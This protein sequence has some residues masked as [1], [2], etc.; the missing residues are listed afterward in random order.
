MWKK[1]IE[2]IKWTLHYITSNLPS[3]YCNGH[4]QMTSNQST[5]NLGK[6]KIK[7][8]TLTHWIQIEF[9]LYL[10]AI[11]LERIYSDDKILQNHKCGNK[12]NGVNKMTIFN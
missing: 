4:I 12:K 9:L 2:L 1:T 10:L 8:I 5:I 11:I 3:I 6:S 7:K